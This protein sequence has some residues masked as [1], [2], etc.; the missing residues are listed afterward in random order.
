[1]ERARERRVSTDFLAGQ[2]NAIGAF[3]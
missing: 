2:L 3:G 1:M